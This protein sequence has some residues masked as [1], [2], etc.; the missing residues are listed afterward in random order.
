MHRR[1]QGRHLK[2]HYRNEDNAQ[3]DLN[4]SFQLG[5]LFKNFDSPSL[6]TLHFLEPC[7][8]S[9]QLQEG[10][11]SPAIYS[12]AHLTGK[13]KDSIRLQYFVLSG[14]PSRFSSG[15]HSVYFFSRDLLTSE[16]VIISN[17]I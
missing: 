2:S 12:Q 10:S 11:L 16:K 1:G 3:F 8:K 17:A 6:K 4:M 5:A 13:I 15:T 7:R 9:Y 14:T